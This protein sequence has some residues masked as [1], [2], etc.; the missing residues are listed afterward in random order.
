DDRDGAA[1][2]LELAAQALAREQR[3]ADLRA[4]IGETRRQVESVQRPAWHAIQAEIDG[5]SDD[6]AAASIETRAS[7][8]RRDEGG[9]W[10]DRQFDRFDNLISIRREDEVAAST[11]HSR[12]GAAAALRR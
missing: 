8:P 10:W 11:P 7:A 12:D 1:A 6:L 3:F 4:A 2:A 9:G 5:I